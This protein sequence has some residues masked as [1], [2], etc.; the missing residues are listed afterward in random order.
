M[1]TGKEKGDLKNFTR[2]DLTS[3]KL[4]GKMSDTYYPYFTADGNAFI[5]FDGKNIYR[6]L[7]N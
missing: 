2:V 1:W 5:K 7:T 3:G 4:L 6:Y